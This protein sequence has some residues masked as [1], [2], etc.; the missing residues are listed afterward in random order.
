MIHTNVY[1][2]DNK[3]EYNTTGLLFENYSDG[4]GIV[5]CHEIS[6][7][8]SYGI[9]CKTYSD[10]LIFSSNTIHD[11]G[12]GYAGIYG[13]GSSVF[14]LGRYSDQGHNSIY[15]NDPYE[16]YSS[17]S[18]TIYAKYNWWGDSSPDPNVS[19]NVDWSNY[20]TSDPNTMLAKAVTRQSHS[21]SPI[22]KVAASNDTIG[23]SEVDYAYLIYRKADYQTAA[24]LFETIIH[25]YPGHFSGRRALAFLYKCNKH[26]SKDSE[27][28][29]L[30]DNVSAT[31]PNQE[32]DALSKNISVAEFTNSDNKIIIRKNLRLYFSILI[33][34]FLKMRLAIAKDKIHPKYMYVKPKKTLR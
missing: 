15:Y 29:T 9:R 26:L 21:G 16:V 6:F 30:L 8:S 27:N 28:L 19:S 25:K 3:I 17:Y 4:S 12:W 5:N 11:N 24:M 33:S 31:Y 34:F 20:L 14:D 32:I 23:I 18:G 1:L 13:D 22:M 2:H 7:N 10:P